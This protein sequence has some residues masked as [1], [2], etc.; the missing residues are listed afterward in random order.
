MKMSTGSAP[1]A[2]STAKLPA[3]SDSK[4]ATKSRSKQSRELSRN[5]T[6]K[7]KALHPRKLF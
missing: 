4:K 3:S 2:V 1:S 7:V 6:Q 5:D